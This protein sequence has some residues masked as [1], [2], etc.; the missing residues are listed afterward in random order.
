MG[1]KVLVS[2]LPSAAHWHIVFHAGS[3][4]H[5]C[6]GSLFSKTVALKIGLCKFWSVIAAK[7]TQSQRVLWQAHQP[8]GVEGMACR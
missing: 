4:I 2:F 1:L 7:N 6:N 8:D 3:A 5:L